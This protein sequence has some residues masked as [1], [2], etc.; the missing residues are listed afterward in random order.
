MLLRIH[1]LNS[2]LMLLLLPS[3]SISVSDEDNC[4]LLTWTTPQNIK[5]D[6]VLEAVICG[7][8]AII[9]AQL[10]LSV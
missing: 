4:L 9:L 10:S 6:N 7:K 8:F 3:K 2:L 5:K 1:G